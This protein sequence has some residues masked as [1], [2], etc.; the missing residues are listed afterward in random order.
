MPV[1]GR[2]KK[3]DPKRMSW[4]RLGWPFP[5][6][7]QQPVA[8][9]FTT[10]PCLSFFAPCSSCLRSQW[11]PERYGSEMSPSP[12]S[13]DRGGCV[14]VGNMWSPFGVWTKEWERKGNHPCG[15]HSTKL[16]NWSWE[17]QI[18]QKLQF[19]GDCF[20]DSINSYSFFF[21]LCAL[22]SLW[23]LCKCTHMLFSFNIQRLKVFNIFFLWQSLF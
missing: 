18:S 21:S 1:W 9:A 20:F 11:N 13:W 10:D 14:N 4:G 19:S 22:T 5:Q 3:T 16:I 8:G 15:K 17:T 12:P 6:P 23:L 7:C 2:R